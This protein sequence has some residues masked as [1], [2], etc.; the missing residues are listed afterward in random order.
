MP[1]Y[2]PPGFGKDNKVIKVGNKCYQYNGP[3]SQ[4]EQVVNIDEVFQTCEECEAP[5]NPSPSPSLIIP[6]PSP[7]L[8]PSPSPE[9]LPT[10]CPTFLTGDYKLSPYTDGDISCV[11]CNPVGFAAWNGVFPYVSACRWENGELPDL[12]IDGGQLY[13]AEVYWTV[14]YWEIFIACESGIGEENWLGYWRKYDG[15]TPEG[16]YDIASLT[17]CSESSGIPNQLSIVEA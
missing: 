7:S 11:D 2:L 6:S 16:T 1:L 4:D 8:G 9:P 15:A 17:E 5:A 3:S 10:S 14:N 13:F 12:A